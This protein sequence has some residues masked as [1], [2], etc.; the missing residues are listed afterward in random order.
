MLLVADRSSEAQRDELIRL[1]RKL[2][3]DMNL[4]I[5]THRVR[6]VSAE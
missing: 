4:S 6:P 1:E 5:F 3:L 2:P